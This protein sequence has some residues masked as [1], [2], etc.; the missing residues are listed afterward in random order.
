MIINNKLD[1]SFGK[2]AVFAGLI[3]F[4]S[5]CL[6]ITY[7]WPVFF[8]LVSSFIIFTRS[9]IQIDTEKRQVRL[10]QNLFG[11]YK[12]GK[13]KTLD[14][15]KGLIL[16]PIKR[17]FRMASMSNRSATVE[18]QDFRIFLVNKMNKPDFPIKKCKTLEDAQSRIDELSLWLKLPVYTIKNGLKD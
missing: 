2:F 13:W 10:Y 14:L 16:I 3:V 9:G 4:I 8:I 12:T 15:Y 17:Y 5:G 6:T 18:E 11:I 7:I 1:R